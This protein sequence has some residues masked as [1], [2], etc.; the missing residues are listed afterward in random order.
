MIQVVANGLQDDYSEWEE[1]EPVYLQSVVMT[2]IWKKDVKKFVYH[3][4]KTTAISFK[5]F[6][7]KL[8][9][10][11]KRRDAVFGAAASMSDYHPE[12][13]DINFVEGERGCGVGCCVLVVVC[14]QWTARRTGECTQ[15]L[16]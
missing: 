1:F 10:V 7:K 2:E 15:S 4:P 12:D 5:A 14:K 11:L 9:I 8:K 6:D 16:I 13:L 3:Y